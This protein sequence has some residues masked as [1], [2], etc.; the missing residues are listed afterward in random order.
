MC[1]PDQPNTTMGFEGRFDATQKLPA[2][3]LQ[4]LSPCRTVDVVLCRMVRGGL[5]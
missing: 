5:Q 2:R 3:T 4:S 1:Q